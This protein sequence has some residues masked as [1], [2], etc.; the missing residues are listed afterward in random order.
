MC[1]RFAIKSTPDYLRRLLGF[2]ERPNFP[3]RYN[4]APMQPIPLVRV[5]NGARH[6]I[7]ARWGLIP[8]WVKDP[9]QFALLINARAEGIAEKPSFRA[10]IRRRRCLVPADGFYEWRREGK[11]KR[12]YFIRARG[13][14][15]MAFAGIW[16]T[17][18]G[19]DGGEIDTAAII[20]C[21]ANAVLA[22]IHARMPVVIP[23]EAFDRWLDPDETKF[24]E[25]CVLLKPAPD[26]FMEAYEV[27]PRVNKAAH[28]DAE[29]IVPVAS[30]ADIKAA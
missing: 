13:G 11:S 22:P 30:A 24:K 4:I 28:D 1:G 5:E 8:S 19:A 10:A 12:P 9:R 26:D 2:V 18:I 16:E 29:N 23:P 21:A 25:A 15:P 20:T 7:L 17:W 14:E 6:F 3:P 27:S